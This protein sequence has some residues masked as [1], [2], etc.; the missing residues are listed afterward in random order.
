MLCKII[1]HISHKNV[2]I[3]N[4]YVDM[5]LPDVKIINANLTATIRESTQL[6]QRL[7]P[8]KT[9]LPF[10]ISLDNPYIK[11]IHICYDVL[12]L[13]ADVLASL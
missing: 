6:H 12:R 9:M 8:E 4:N 2:Y 5:Y 1:H 13:S 7:L 11:A 10:D 3:T